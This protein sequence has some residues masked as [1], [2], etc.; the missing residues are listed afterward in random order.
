[1]GEAMR[2]WIPGW[3]MLYG[4]GMTTSNAEPWQFKGP[5][6]VAVNSED[7]VYVAEINS[8][9]IAKF[10]ADGQWM[11][12]ITEVDGYGAFAGP[13][14]VTVGPGD[15]I[16]I[17]D[18]FNHKVLVLD[19]EENLQFVLGK[20]PKSA[21]PEHFIE[22]HFVAVNQRGEIFVSDT[23]NARI[24][25]FAPDGTFIRTWG[26]IGEGPGEFLLTGYL[27]GIA[28]DNQGHVYVRETDGG[29]IQKFT[30]DGEY[31]ATIGKRGVAPG[32]LDEG[33]GAAIIGNILYAVD[34]F[35]SR[36]QRFMPDG[37]LVDVWDPGEGNRG[38]HFNHPV[39]IARAGAGNLI[40]TDW[41]NDRVVEL[42][43]QGEFLR[44][45]GGSMEDLLAYEAPARV[46][47]PSDKRIDIS[48]YGSVARRDLDA[49]RKYGVDA[50]YCSHDQQDGDWPIADGV[51]IANEMGIKVHTSIAMFLFGKE[52]EFARAH[53]EYF[54]WKRDAAAPVNTILSWA[55]PAVRTYRARHLHQQ[56][57]RTGVNGIML[58]YIRYLGNDY[59]YD[60]IVIDSYL[61]AYGV[62][63]NT[64]PSDD[65]QWMQFR[66][67]YV[68]EFIVELRRRLADLDD[69]PVVSA[70]LSGDDPD[71][72]VYLKSSLQDWRT[73]AN[74]GI[75]DQLNVAHYTRDFDRIYHAVQR[76]R[77]A[78]PART[79]INCFLACYGGNL[80]EPALLQK[81]VDVSIAAGADEVTIYRSDAI[82]ELD[83]WET[84]GEIAD[85]VNGRIPRLPEARMTPDS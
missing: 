70:Y 81:G 65:P 21:E 51:R 10:T 64:L 80:N 41:K 36:I 39:G 79:R 17:A 75:V 69:P 1:M 83:L 72:A 84:I 46:P 12:A 52:G 50:V 54:I 61:R 8:R 27:G 66:A 42:S 67:D 47:R 58:D 23:F 18:T 25:K 56:A 26:R 28:C 2:R 62:D 22:P 15:R 20:E 45:W 85:K 24:Q 48:I 49:Y 78:V 16:H 71:P 60:P 76:V 14:D 37:T 74:M 38:H 40:V 3:A 13:F 4:L 7:V 68:T 44:T 30:E 33:Y 43:P 5:F 77:N 55:Q 19:A 31:V 73:W 6:G 82:W 11:G 29:R 34:T 53:P 9:R 35:A 32:E 57:G 59:G 63:P